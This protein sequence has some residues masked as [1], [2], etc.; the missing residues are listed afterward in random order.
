MKNHLKAISA[1]LFVVALVAACAAPQ[2]IPF[3]LVGSAPAV[4]RGTI[5]PDKQQIEVMIEGQQYKGFYLV[6]SGSAF[7]ES[8][9]GWR[10][11]PYQSVTTY[12]SNSAR[13]HLSTDKGERLSCE[14]LF[15]GRQ[16]IG[17]CRTP[18]GAVYQMT[19]NGN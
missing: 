2:P 4:Q 7:S 17:E 18:A 9:G 19:A 14:F 12:A 15:E 3:Q 13:A 16:A 1:S 5:F 10:H 8:Y 11:G 6:A